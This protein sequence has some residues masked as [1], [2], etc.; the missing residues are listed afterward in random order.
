MYAGF[1]DYAI[2]ATRA[3]QRA[4]LEAPS[5]GF[6]QAPQASGAKDAKAAL[7]AAPATTNPWEYFAA[8]DYFN[9]R[10]DSSPNSADYRISGFG[11]IAGARTTIT[12]RIRVGGYFAGDSG[13]VDGSLLDADVTGWS[14]GLYAKAL[15]DD[16]THTLIT[17][18]L[19]YGKYSFDGNRSS[20]IAT[21]GG[22][23]SPGYSGFNNVDSDAF[24]FFLGASSIIYQTDKFRLLPAAGLRYVCGGMDG[25]AETTG[26]P[27]SPVALVVGK[28]SYQSALAEISLRAEA[29]LSARLTLDGRI[30]FTMTLGP[31]DPAALSARF[32]TG[33]RAFRATA[34][35]LDEDAFFCGLGAT[36]RVRDN[37]GVGL[38]WRA[39]FRSDADPENQV[40]L[41]AAFRF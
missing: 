29:D 11:F 25:F 33:N 24:E 40:G 41:S 7:P 18:G 22:G 26:G 8:V 12:D 9:V 13:S 36:W 32:A 14:L 37:F 23:W 17:G 28:D 1:Q 30:G 19:S 2:H 4:A 31:D 15:I 35:G 38:H 5:L 3:H 10:T 6:I 27:G 16:R 34:E 39:D 21:G 20:L